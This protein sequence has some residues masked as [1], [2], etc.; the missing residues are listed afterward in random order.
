MF[1]ARNKIIKKD[2][3]KPTQLEEEVAKGLFDLE[4]KNK[5]LKD[6]LIQVFVAHAEQILYKQRDGTQAKAILVQV[7][8]RSL[9]AFRKTAKAIVDHLENIF[10]CSVFV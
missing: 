8:Y 3:Q 9:N 4:M 6:Q 7:P 2:D 1:N 5:N 10:K